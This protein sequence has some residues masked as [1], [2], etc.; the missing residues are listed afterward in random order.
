MSTPALLVI[1]PP[2]PSRQ[3][4]LDA[5]A[6]V[7]FTVH[8]C[9][10]GAEGLTAFRQRPPDVLVASLDVEDME[11]LALV[12]SVRDEAPDL[13]VSVIRQ[14]ARSGG[15]QVEFEIG[16]AASATAAQVLVRGEL[17]DGDAV[18]EAVETTLDY[19]P[20]QSKAS[21]GLIFR[22]DPAGLAVRI[23]AVGYAD[24]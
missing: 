23:A 14:E 21:G 3:V 19:V 13:S 16:N 12:T 17:V 7:G 20:M 24:P 22:H 4:L 10:T 5:A 9:D 2:S 6:G 11:G 8:V 18:V 15:Y 1:H